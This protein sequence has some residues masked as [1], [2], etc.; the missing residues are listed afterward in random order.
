V[1]IQLPE[2]ST[3]TF[4]GLANLAAAD[5]RKAMM[6][7]LTRGSL[8]LRTEKF[9]TYLFADEHGTVAGVMIP[10]KV[11]YRTKIDDPYSQ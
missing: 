6:A 2:D 11:H 10:F 5:V 1:H 4:D 7:D 9:E 3:S 8:A